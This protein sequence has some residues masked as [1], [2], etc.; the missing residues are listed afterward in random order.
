MLSIQEARI[1]AENAYYAQKE[2]AGFSQEKVDSIVNAIGSGLS[3][4]A[5]DFALMS[6]EETDYGKWE[7]KYIKNKFVCDRLP[8]DL[9]DMRCLGIISENPEKGLMEVGV[10][11]GVIVALCLATSPV[12]TTIYKAL[13][14]IKSGNSIVFSPHPRAKATIGKTLDAIISIGSQYGLPEGAISY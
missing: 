4:Q 2:L 8:R 12:S 14:A 1:L 10:P 11:L 7:D 5:K 3:K 9:R 6:A 13:I